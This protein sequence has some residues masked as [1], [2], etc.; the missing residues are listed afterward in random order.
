MFSDLPIRGEHKFSVRKEDWSKYEVL[1]GKGTVWVRNI[2]IKV[3]ERDVSGVPPDQLPE[4]KDGL[5]P[6]GLLE[7]GIQTLSTAFFSSELRG[8]PSPPEELLNLAT[9]PGGEEIPFKS[10][11]EPWNEYLL[12]GKTPTI[13]RTKCIATKMRFFPKIFNKF[14]DPVIHIDVQQIMSFPHNLES[15]EK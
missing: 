8:E 15:L 2:I 10:I 1:D 9:K 14:G 5:R 11:E 12:A 7:G 3:R 4:T 13:I 6:K